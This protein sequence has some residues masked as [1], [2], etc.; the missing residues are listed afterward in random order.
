VATVL[1][2]TEDGLHT[3]G[4]S[5]RH[6]PGR[7]VSALATDG[8]T[9]WAL[10]DGREV[11][12]DAL[13]SPERIPLPEKVR[14]NCLLP[15][16]GGGLVGTSEARLF[17]VQGGRCDPVAAFDAV[18]ERE[19]WYTPWGGP[20]DTRSMA[21]DRNGTLYVNVHVGGIPISTDG[22]GSFEPSI[23]IDA[24]IHQVASLGT[25]PGWVFAAGARGLSE[26]RDGGR[27]WSLSDRALHASYCRAVALAG[28]TLLLSASTGPRGGSAAVYRRPLDDGAAPFERCTEGLPER[29]DG[30]IDTHCLAASGRLAA[31]GTADGRVFV[32][33]DGGRTWEEGATS[34]PRINCVVVGAAG[35]EQ[36]GVGGGVAPPHRN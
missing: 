4:S 6:E 13:S 20:P 17:Q 24:D 21:R 25:R 15:G 31:F 8:T 30:N 22:G 12:R 35:P 36:V 9:W 5:S 34:L 16:P 7:S 19:K 26:S 28:D 11:V 1:I 14:G 27:K 10:L 29:F 2:G 23:D 18:E 32:S 33:E 3:L